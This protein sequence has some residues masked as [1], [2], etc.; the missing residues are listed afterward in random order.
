M[1]S[2]IVAIIGRTNAGKSTLI[3]NIIGQKVAITSPKPKTT[4]FPIEAVFEDERGQ[5]VFIDTPGMTADTVKESIDLLVYIIDHTR[6]RGFEENKMLGIVRQFKSTPKVLVINKIDVKKPTFKPHYL[7]L[8]D[9]VDEVVEIS[10]LYNKHIKKL[11]DVIYSFLHEGKPIVDTKD[12]VTPLITIDSKLFIAELIREK[13]YLFTGQ[14]VPYKTRV[15]I[16]EVTERKKGA[17]YVKAIIYTEND[18]YKK[19]LIG[20]G[21][22]K[23]KQIGSVARKELELARNKKVYLDLVVES[24]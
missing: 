3:N 17:L 23:I 18:R 10:A 4:R 2:G 8:E 15:E 11:L 24:R 14:E 20:E 5:I 21:G 7:F 22:R 16:E 1:K 12:M 6:K 13:I 19:I 9:E